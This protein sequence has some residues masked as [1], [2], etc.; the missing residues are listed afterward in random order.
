MP[1]VTDVLWKMSFIQRPLIL[2]TAPEKAAGGENH[3]KR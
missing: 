2:T 3:R 1:V